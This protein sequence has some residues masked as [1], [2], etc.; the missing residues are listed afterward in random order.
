[1][2]WFISPLVVIPSVNLTQGYERI[3]DILEGSEI[4]SIWR[5]FLEVQ[6]RN[7]HAPAD[8]ILNPEFD[9]GTTPST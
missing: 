3:G 2:G 1:M 4:L 8:Q 6:G 9:P 5:E 7:P